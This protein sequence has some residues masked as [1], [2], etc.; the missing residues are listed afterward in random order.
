V[1]LYVL[2]FVQGWLILVEFGAI[3][4]EFLVLVPDDVIHPFDLFAEVF[5]FGFE[6]PA[7][8]FELAQSVVV[9]FEFIDREL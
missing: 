2:E 7:S 8:L 9:S 3:V 5:Y 6:F 1:N 4:V